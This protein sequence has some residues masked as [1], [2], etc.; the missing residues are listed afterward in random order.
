[1]VDITEDSKDKTYS[2]TIR[3]LKKRPE[4]TT[5][6]NLPLSREENL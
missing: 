2:Y 5:P 1:M 3:K 4:N 6:P